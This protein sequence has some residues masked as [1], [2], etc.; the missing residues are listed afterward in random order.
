[1]IR[2]LHEGSIGAGMRRVEALVGPDALR[3]INAERALLRGLV[4]ALGCEGPA[5]RPSS[6]RAASSRRTSA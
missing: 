6:T 2:I 5:R 4:E 3:E 1:M